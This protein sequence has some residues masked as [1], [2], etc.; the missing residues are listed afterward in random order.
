M[1]IFLAINNPLG[2]LQ[3]KFESL[4]FNVDMDLSSINIALATKQQQIVLHS[5]GKKAY[6]CNCE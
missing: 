6:L 1:D 5:K 3:T 2:M 4:A